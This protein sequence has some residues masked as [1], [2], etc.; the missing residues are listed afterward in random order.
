ML[1]FAYVSALAHSS[2]WPLSS[3]RS[4][5]EVRFATFV[6]A[7]VFVAYS[8][9]LSLDYPPPLRAFT[10]NFGFVLGLLPWAPATATIARLT[11]TSGGVNSSS[12]GSD[13]FY[14]L[15][16]TTGNAT[17][18]NTLVAASASNPSAVPGFSAQSQGPPLGLAAYAEALDVPRAA[19]FL[20]CVRH[21][22]LR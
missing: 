17:L 12:T 3:D 20:Q 19:I 11:Q 7:L 16:E 22:D 15:D 9:A 10:E 1:V 18:Y 2:F 4:A 13:V 5:P 14:D 8:G 21:R 6:H